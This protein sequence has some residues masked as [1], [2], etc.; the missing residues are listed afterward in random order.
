MSFWRFLRFRSIGRLWRRSW[1]PL[2]GEERERL[3]QVH[4]RVLARFPGTPWVSGG[5]WSWYS[6]SPHEEEAPP[7]LMMYQ[8]LPLAVL[9]RE[10]ER[11]RRAAERYGIALFTLDQSDEQL[12]AVLLQLEERAIRLER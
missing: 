12:D 9:R 5:V 6:G 1:L 11:I 3:R 4:E 8:Y 7:V 2:S 10:E